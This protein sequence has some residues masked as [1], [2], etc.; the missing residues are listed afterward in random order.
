MF[1]L[2]NSS[3]IFF[4]ELV[5]KYNIKIDWKV[6]WIIY[7]L[8]FSSDIFP[9]WRREYICRG[10]FPTGVIIMAAIHSQASS[11]RFTENNNPILE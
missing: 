3:S 9:E 4:Q 1:V 10:M 11:Y 6:E 7:I 2:K 5:F 8:K